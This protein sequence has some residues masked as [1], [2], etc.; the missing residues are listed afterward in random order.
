LA[1][2]SYKKYVDKMQKNGI[3]QKPLKISW[4]TIYN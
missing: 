3:F 4:L 1:E 2:L